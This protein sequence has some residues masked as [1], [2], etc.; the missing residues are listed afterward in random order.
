MSLLR[1]SFTAMGTDCGL[2]VNAAPSDMAIAHRA[3][4]A[5]LAELTA[6]ERA[7]SRFDASSGLSQLNAVSGSWVEVDQRLFHAVKAAVEARETTGG[8]FDPTVLPALVA[9]GYDR[10]FTELQPRDAGSLAGWSAGAAIDLDPVGRRVRLAPGTKIDLGGIGKGLSATAALDTMRT[11]WPSDAG[12][13]RRPR[14]RHRRRRSGTGRSLA[15]RRR[16]SPHAGW[17]A[18]RAGADRRRCG[19]IRPRPPPVRPRPL[20]APPDRPC[21]GSAGGAGSARCDGGGCDHG[22]GRGARNHARDHA[23]G[24][25]AGVRDQHPGLSAL[26]VPATDHPFTCGRIPLVERDARGGRGGMIVA[27][28][29]PTAWL[30]A[31]AAGLVAFGVLTLSTWLGLGMST[32]LAGAEVPGPAARL[33]P[34]ARMDGPEPDRPP[35]RRADARSADALR[36]SR[37]AGAV[38]GALAPGGSGRRCRGRLADPDAGRVLPDAPAD[39]P[40]RVAAPALRELRRLPAVARPCTGRRHRSGRN[41]RA[42][43]GGRRRR[44]GALAHARSHP[45]AA[46]RAGPR[47][48]RRERPAGLSPRSGPCPR[49]T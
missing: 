37:G 39:R 16:R 8:R 35:R 4:G 7:L 32:R 1:H 31:R 46:T 11:T 13:P 36:P 27:A 22:R 25:I 9:A 19:H 45:D 29:L 28:G 26:V 17:T 34:H 5:A 47:R 15:D 30:V 38:R 49:P 6:L 44:A 43:P 3:I 24:A 33:A 10:T 23:G 40:A 21:H 18:W 12:C 42:D 20:P 14:W 48:R 41:R 2:V